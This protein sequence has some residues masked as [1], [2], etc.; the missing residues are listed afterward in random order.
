MSKAFA[1]FL[2]FVIAVGLFFSYI[3]PAYKAVQA[4]KVQE[5]RL[6]DALEDTKELTAQR[7][8]LLQRYRDISDVNRSKLNKLLPD[9]VDNV[10]LIIDIDSIAETY[11]LVIRDYA[12]REFGS[13]AADTRSDQNPLGTASLSFS[14]L[15]SYADF[16]AFLYDIES[17][18]RLMDVTLLEVRAGTDRA[19]DEEE[20][21]TGNTYTVSVQTYWL[22]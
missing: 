1:P 9:N 2:F 11:N 20:A 5:S 8:T 19:P 22:K 18:L 7:S 12:F 10:R 21:E 14:V 6:D 17:S 13:T 16:K 15:G 4:L 3:D